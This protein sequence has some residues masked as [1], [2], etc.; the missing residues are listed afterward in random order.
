MF[1]MYQMYSLTASTA[2]IPPH[3]AKPPARQLPHREHMQADRSQ[4]WGFTLQNP[5]DKQTLL[6]R[7]CPTVSSCKRR[8]Q[9]YSLWRTDTPLGVPKAYSSSDRLGTAYEAPL[10]RT[11]LS[12]K[13]GGTGKL[14]KPMPPKPYEGRSDQLSFAPVMVSCE[15][16]SCYDTRYADQ[17]QP[18]CI[19]HSQP[20]FLF[21]LQDGSRP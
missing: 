13:S 9:V 16:V 12:P 18:M 14:L 1:L 20:P 10:R 17:N 7:E 21:V 5:L 2:C 15:K 11:M 3:I 6:S 4:P 8:C 19:C